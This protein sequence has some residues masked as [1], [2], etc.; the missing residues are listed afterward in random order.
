MWY[1]SADYSEFGIMLR[2]PQHRRCGEKVFSIFE[3][4]TRW[5]SKGK[6]GCP[7]E[8]G[9]PVCIL[10]D[11]HGF[12]LRP[13]VMREGGD[14]DHAVPM[15]E[16]AQS[17]FPGLR[18]EL[19]P[20]L[21]KSREPGPPR[22]AARLQRAA[23]EGLSQRGRTRERERQGLRPCRRP[24]RGR[25]ERPPHRPASAPPG[26]PEDTA[27][28][29]RLTEPPQTRKLQTPPGTGREDRAPV[30]PGGANSSPEIAV[31]RPDSAVRPGSRHRSRRRIRRRGGNRSRKSRNGWAFGR[32]RAMLR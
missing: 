7:V 15:V 19:R 20:R 16:A 24:L 32:T 8:L 10:E 31:L 3:P 23:E 17:A 25:P 30:S 18:G 1:K 13:E 5:I 9:V 12:V 28:A 2:F 14:V 26:A 22:R 29:R 6:A 27:A 21:P 11:E 4:H